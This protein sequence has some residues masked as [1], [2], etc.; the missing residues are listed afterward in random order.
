[1]T[2]ICSKCNKNKELDNFYKRKNSYRSDCKACKKEL[3]KKW[4]TSNRERRAKTAKEWCNNNLDYRKEWGRKNKACRN[5]YYNKQRKENTNFRIAG[6]LRN[7]LNM[8]I[9]NNQKVGS[10]V[11]DLGCPIKEFKKHLE[12][13]WQPGM[14]WDNYGLY[15]WH[16]DHIVPLCKFDLKNREELFKAVHY[17]NLQPLW[18]KENLSKGGK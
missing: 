16:I 5:E 11:R 1:M 3:D 4:T 18:A 7:R 13:Q 15:G 9:R 6:N 12:A 10:A 17:T 2:K 14:S 8:A